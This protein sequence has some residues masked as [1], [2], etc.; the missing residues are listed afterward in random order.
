MKDLAVKMRRVLFSGY[1]WEVK[2]SC[3]TCVGPGP[4]YFSG[5]ESSVFVDEKGLHL[6]TSYYDDKYFSSEV[7]LSVP[8]GFGEYI[9]TLDFSAH[10]LDHL[11]VLSGF[12]YKDDNT[13][14]DIEFSGAMCGEDKAQYVI[15]PGRK[16][17]NLF[18]FP[19]SKDSLTTH[20]ITWRPDSVEFESFIG[21]E[22]AYLKERIIA[23]HLYTGSDIPQTKDLKMIFNLWLYEGKN[24]E[25]LDEVIVK[26]F[27][28]KPLQNI[29]L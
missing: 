6:T 16:Y 5:R 11:A 1:W 13:E 9:F 21:D 28:F 17:G 4:N 27:S 18:I 23:K 14:I 19:M 24:P 15:Q 2:E 10:K 29:L 25:K 3:G 12:L 8:L 7:A 26:N 22:K 20:K